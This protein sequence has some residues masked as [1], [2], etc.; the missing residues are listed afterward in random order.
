VSYALA[1]SLQARV[2]ARLAGDAALSALV[3]E[4]IYD[5]PPALTPAETEYVTLG[6]ESVR[7]FGTKTS[8]G[9]IHDFAVTVHSGRD[10]FDTVK[11]A[12]E[13]VC[14]ALVD[15]PLALDAGRLVALRFLR[16]SAERGRAPA[17]RRVVLRFRAVVDED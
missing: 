5:A 15:A 12:A 11:R 4:A 6:E 1:S 8:D 17:K 7:D 10:G 3:G 2:Y 16:A 9:A 13:A 14:A